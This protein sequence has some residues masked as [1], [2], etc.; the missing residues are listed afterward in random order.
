M[1]ILQPHTPFLFRERP[2]P[3]PGDLR[4]SWRFALNLLVLNK[5]RAKRSSLARLYIMNDAARSFDDA[6]LLS[7][8]LIG[9]SPISEWRIKVEPALGRALDLMVGEDLLGWVTVA[10]RLGVELSP[11][12]LVLAKEID[13]EKA[14]MEA[15]KERIRFLSSDLTEGRVTEFLTVK[16]DHAL[17]DF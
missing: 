13:A 7:D 9:A 5:S 17:L 3:V 6:D 2:S 4:I 10:G 8:I 1:A 14:I 15:E 16:A 12:G 11:T